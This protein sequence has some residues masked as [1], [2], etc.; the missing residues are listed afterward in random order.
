MK[1]NRKG[2]LF[3]VIGRICRLAHKVTGSKRLL[4]HQRNPC[5]EFFTLQ[6]QRIRSFK[7]KHCTPLVKPHQTKAAPSSNQVSRCVRNHGLIPW[8]IW[9]CCILNYIDLESRGINVAKW[10][11]R[12]DTQHWAILFKPCF[13]GGNGIEK[14]S[15]EHKKAHTDWILPDMTKIW[16]PPPKAIPL[17]LQNINLFWDVLKVVSKQNYAQSWCLWLSCGVHSSWVGPRANSNT[18]E[19]Y[20]IDSYLFPQCEDVT[21]LQT[22]PRYIHHHY[23]IKILHN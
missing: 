14:I 7:T 5:S 3:E 19:P 23:I 2:L 20:H 8:N 10:R 18:R 9:N 4:I 21:H 6:L 1:T 12:I 16:T 11:W 22:P 15:L 17:E 13:H